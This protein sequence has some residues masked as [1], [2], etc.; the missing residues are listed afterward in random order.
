[1]FIKRLDGDMYDS[2]IDILYNLFDLVS[3]GG[4]I[5]IDDFGWEHG[6]SPKKPSIWGAKDAVL[7][8]RAV[9]GIEDLE[10]AMHNID[11]SGAWFQKQREVK[12]KRQRYLHC[13]NTSD[14]QPLRPTPKLTAMDYLRLMDTWEKPS[15]P[16]RR[17]RG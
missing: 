4:Y 12:L 15:E 13:V 10:H 3:V 2:T 14:Y 5:V 9:H 8:F 16:A 17:R 7:D 1:M 11:G 6:T